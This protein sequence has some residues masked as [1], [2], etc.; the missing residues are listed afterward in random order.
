MSLIAAFTAGDSE[1][2]AAT[3]PHV[4]EMYP[5]YEEDDGLLMAAE[6]MGEYDTEQ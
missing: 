3:I 5:T 2:Q 6:D 1:S 4:V